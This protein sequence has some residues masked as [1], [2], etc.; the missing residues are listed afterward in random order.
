M[1]KHQ[2]EF[3]APYIALVGP[4]NFFTDGI[5]IQSAHYCGMDIS[6]AQGGEEM[7]KQIL[8]Q[9]MHK[10][11]CYREIV[12]QTSINYD[13][14]SLIFGSLVEK[15]FFDSE[16]VKLIES[17]KCDVSDDEWWDL[18]MSI[19]VRQELNSDGD[20]KRNWAQILTHRGKIAS[21]TADL[22][23]NFIAYRAGY[24]DGFSWTL[25]EN[26]ARWFQN[27]FKEQFGDI[28]FLKKEFSREEVVFYT[29]ARN[30]Q[31]IVVIP[32]KYL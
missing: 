25:D 18:V 31:E 5:F 3:W 27:R 2:R 13:D 29:N 24:D 6:V 12:D 15:P 28:P 1:N 19:W 11:H 16:L 10:H 17:N 20:R 21:L 26:T 9:V 4:S 14:L 32:S 30:E 7:A 23:N 8:N 22:S